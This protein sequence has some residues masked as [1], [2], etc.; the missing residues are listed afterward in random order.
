MSVLFPKGGNR[1]LRLLLGCCLRNGPEFGVELLL[2][3][4]TLDM[5]SLCTHFISFKRLN[6]FQA[7]MDASASSFL[8]V[9][10]Q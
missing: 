1:A 8:S 7:P 5:T 4:V 10:V 6:C 9:T 3:G 2:Q